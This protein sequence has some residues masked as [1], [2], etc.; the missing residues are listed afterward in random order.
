M[1]VQAPHAGMAPGSDHDMTLLDDALHA[2]AC[3]LSV[4]GAHAGEDAGVIFARKIEDCKAVGRTFWVVKSAK[5]RPAQVQAMCG[6]ESRYVIFVEPS[7]P[8]G[9]RPTVAAK[10]AAEYSPDGVAWSPMPDGLGPVT[11]RMDRSAA[12]LVFEELTTVDDERGVD[13][14]EYTDGLDPGPPLR[15][16]LGRSTICAVREDTSGHPRRMKSRYRRAVAVAR[17]VSPFCVWL[18]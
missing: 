14:W 4:M 17:L 6:Q 15:F 8:G 12:A 3:V 16:A 11:G 2:P 13:L 9:A 10:S 18:R 1:K 7:S 5:A